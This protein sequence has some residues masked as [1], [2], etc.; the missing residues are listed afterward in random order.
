MLH[1]QSPL[2]AKNVRRFPFRRGLSL[3]RFLFYSAKA[4]AGKSARHSKTRQKKLRLKEQSPLTGAF[5]SLF[6]FFSFNPLLS[7]CYVLTQQL[8]VNLK[9]SRLLIFSTACV[10]TTSPLK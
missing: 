10:Q 1:L 5:K 6:L 9:I 3:R 2:K 8:A 4:Q 7:T